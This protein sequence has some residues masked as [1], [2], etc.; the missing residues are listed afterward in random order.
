MDAER[1]GMGI[2]GKGGKG[3]AGQ[4]MECVMYVF[5][6]YNPKNIGLDNPNN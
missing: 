1:E 3:T 2:G 4:P 6:L 5:G